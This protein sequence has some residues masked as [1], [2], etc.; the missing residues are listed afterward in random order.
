[1]QHR[2][3]V[4]DSAFWNTRPYAPAIVG[5]I[6]HGAENAAFARQPAPQ[7]RRTAG[8]SMFLSLFAH[9]KSLQ[10]IAVSVNVISDDIACGIHPSCHCADSPA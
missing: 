9:Q 6:K 7:F 1:M 3:D 2:D 10:F 5:W 4:T 8:E